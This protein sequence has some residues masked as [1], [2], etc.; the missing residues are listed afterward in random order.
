ME[1]LMSETGDDHKGTFLF[2]VFN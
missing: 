1:V 2:W